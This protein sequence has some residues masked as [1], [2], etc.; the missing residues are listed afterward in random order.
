MEKR[1]STVFWAWADQEGELGM[2]MREKNTLRHIV[3]IQIFV[4]KQIL[5]QLSEESGKRLGSFSLNCCLTKACNLCT[6]C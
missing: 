2:F 1:L 6:E 3:S 5:I 4:L